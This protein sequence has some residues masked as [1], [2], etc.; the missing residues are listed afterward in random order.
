MATKNV[1]SQ[2]SKNGA[3]L[4]WVLSGVPANATPIVFGG[5][6][7][8]WDAPTNTLLEAEACRTAFVEQ[9]V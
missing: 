6:L 3:K 5:K 2:A 1:P 4:G 7:W 9:D 8:F